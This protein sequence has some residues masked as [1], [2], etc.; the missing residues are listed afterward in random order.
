MWND[1]QQIQH[2]IGGRAIGCWPLVFLKYS[3]SSVSFVTNWINGTYIPSVSSSIS[4]HLDM[5]VKRL[6]FRQDLLCSPKSQDLGPNCTADELGR[7]KMSPKYL[8]NTRVRQGCWPLC[9]VPWL[10]RPGGG[11]SSKMCHIQLFRET[12]SYFAVF[13]GAQRNIPTMLLLI[14][15]SG[16]KNARW[17]SAAAATARGRAGMVG[18]WA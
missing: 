5:S 9:I 3:E 1:L 17:T 10:W 14:K 18:F 4:N 2:Y 16:A 12:T 13:A 15:L 11:E 7:V 6:F 8:H